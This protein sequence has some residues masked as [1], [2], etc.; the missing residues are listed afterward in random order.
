MNQVR[1]SSVV[2]CV[3][4]VAIAASSAFAADGADA[5]KLVP[6]IRKAIAGYEHRNYRRQYEQNYGGRLIGKWL[7]WKITDL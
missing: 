4:A 6:K 5:E 3:A 2:L 1:F 7:D